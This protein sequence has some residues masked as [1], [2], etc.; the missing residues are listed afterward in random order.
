MLSILIP[1]KDYDC[2][3]LVETLH[4]QGESAGIDLEIIVA[5]D[6]S[7]PHGI[8]MNK[9]LATLPHC[10]ILTQEKNIGRAAIRN[11]LAQEA[12]GK[13]LLFIDSD[14]LCE[15]D[16]FL[17]AYTKALEKSEVVCGGLYHQTELHDPNCTLR[18]RY[19]RAADKRRSA[20]ERKKSPYANFSTFCFAI[21]R[22]L[23]MQ[24]RFNEQIKKY[25]YE[26]TLFGHELKRRHIEIAHIDAPL[27]HTGLESNSIY[28]AKIEDSLKTL[29]E[30]DVQIEETPLLCL[31]NKINR[32]HLVPAVAAA[33]K[34]AA[35]ALRSNLLS[36]HPSLTLL[37]IYKIGYF[38]NLKTT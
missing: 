26:D 13:D 30:I 9:P 28:L 37:K 4:R 34:M 6:G 32:M 23:F 19:E 36:N 5:E 21:R 1:T 20:K 22:E 16:S 29:S 35:P 8:A 10:R 12:R 18:Y 24:I 38:C 17:P 2:R 27:L 7:S 25:G 31:Y 11:M 33:W 15:S 14:A 3:T